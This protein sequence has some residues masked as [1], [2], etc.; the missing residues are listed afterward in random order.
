MPA[1]YLAWKA[2]LPELQLKLAAGE[3]IETVVAPFKI[4]A[5]DLASA[6]RFQLYVIHLGLEAV[7][8]AV[9]GTHNR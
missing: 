2:L 3:S 1:A 6:I 5:L 8:T 9:S 7:E 4:Q